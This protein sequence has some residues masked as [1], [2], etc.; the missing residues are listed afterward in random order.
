MKASTN[1]WCIQGT[2]IRTSVASFN[3]VEGKNSSINIFSTTIGR[4][5]DE[6]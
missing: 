5:D 3:R 6:A 2:M 1:V 4:K